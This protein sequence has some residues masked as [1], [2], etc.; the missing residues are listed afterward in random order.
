MSVKP[1]FAP[2]RMTFLLPFMRGLLQG[3]ERDV[4]D[5]PLHTPRLGPSGEGPNQ[6]RRHLGVAAKPGGVS[7]P[8]QGG[9]RIASGSGCPPSVGTV[10][11]GQRSHANRVIGPSRA[12]MKPDSGLQCPGPPLPPA[13]STRVAQTE[14]LRAMRRVVIDVAEHGREWRGLA[15]LRGGAEAT[16][17]LRPCRRLPPRSTLREDAQKSRRGAIARQ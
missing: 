11:R 2:F 5:C 1:R 4:P 8:R 13:R 14:A 10:E 15:R 3:L 16:S 9:R 6:R 12:K 17:Q 7:R